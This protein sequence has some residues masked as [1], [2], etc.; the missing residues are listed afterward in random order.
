VRQVANGLEDFPSQ[1]AINLTHD[2]EPSF[3]AMASA[4]APQRDIIAIGNA[5]D[6][7]KMAVTHTGRVKCGK[8]ENND[9]QN[10]VRRRRSS[11]F[12]CVCVGGGEEEEEEEGIRCRVQQEKVYTACRST[13]IEAAAST[14][15]IDHTT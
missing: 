13:Q 7:V 14:R 2:G 15:L 8:R 5:A 12:V 4:L 3:A 9:V 1:V 10:Q 11:R 6:V